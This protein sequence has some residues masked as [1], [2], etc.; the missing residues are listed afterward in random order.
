[1]TDASAV[2]VIRTVDLER[3]YSAGDVAVRALRGVSLRIERGEFVAIMGASGCGKS[4]LMNVL[5]CLDQP[6]RG[7]Y[8]LLGRDVSRLADDELADV[9]NRTIGFVF[10]SFNLL[11]RTS[12]VE[13]VELPLLYGELS[14][15]EQRARALA[16]LRRVGLE[17]RETS[18]PAQ[19]SG[20]QQQRVAIARALVNEPEL[21][22]ADEPTGNLDSRTSE[23]IL[24]LFAGLHERGMTIVLVTHENDV[25]AHA[26]RV[27]VMRDGQVVED[28]RTRGS[29]A[30]SMAAAPLAP[31]EMP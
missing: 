15:S 10:Q 23:E 17:G 30:P 11:P 16:A 26:A 13:N 8:E 18:T 22:L 6:T 14:A 31:P 9:R 1:M 3:V 19:L 24:A 12:A 4:T 21:V 2:P 25:A 20:G 5:G 29:G 27:V 28:R 7:R